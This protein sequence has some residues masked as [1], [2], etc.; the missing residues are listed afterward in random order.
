MM[1]HS[2]ITALQHP[3]I[4]AFHKFF[5]EYH[6]FF[7]VGQDRFR[8]SFR[9]Y[10]TGDQRYF[11]EQSHYI[12]TPVQDAEDP[13]L[14]ERHARPE[15]ALSRAVESVT[16]YYEDAVAKGHAPNANWFVRNDV[17]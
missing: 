6:I 4:V 3:H 2:E 5:S 11:I 12:R 9:V 1:S 7:D 14:N 10:E 16:T 15:D 8:M 13:A 17:F